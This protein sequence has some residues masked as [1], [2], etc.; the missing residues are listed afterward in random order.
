MIGLEF[1]LIFANFTKTSITAKYFIKIKLSNQKYQVP[2][3][4]YIIKKIDSACFGSPG[5][6]S[7][8]GKLPQ[9]FSL[10]AITLLCIIVYKCL[11]N[12]TD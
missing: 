2:E 11:V 3:L 7:I 12:K 1:D 6:D 9:I 8:D 10:K 5:S 4:F